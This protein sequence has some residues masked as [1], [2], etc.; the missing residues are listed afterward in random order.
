MRVGETGEGG[1]ADA[2]GRAAP[3]DQFTD[4]GP[5]LTQAIEPRANHQPVRIGDPVEPGVDPWVASDG[6]RPAEETV[7]QD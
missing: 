2:G 7:H 1:V 4:I 5:A 3:A 6:A